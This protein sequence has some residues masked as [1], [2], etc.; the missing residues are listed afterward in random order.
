MADLDP[1]LRRLIAAA[2]EGDHT[3]GLTLLLG[4]S[5]VQG[6]LVSRKEFD[7][8][9]Y[10]LAKAA[11]MKDV[12]GRL[13][14]SKQDL[15]KAAIGEANNQVSRFGSAEGE[16]PEDALR[17]KNVSVASFTGFALEMP[18]IRVSPSH[19]GAWWAGSFNVRNPSGSSAGVGIGFAF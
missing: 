8:H 3:P 15:E 11:S 9:V 19:L 2:E 17:L 18:L 16:V 5:V 14:D 7:H 1:V 4:S 6:V 10:N 12:R 13:W